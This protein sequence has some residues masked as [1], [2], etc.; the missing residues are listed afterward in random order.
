M[1]AKVIRIGAKYCTSRL[2]YEH[3]PERWEV[4]AEKYLREK[5]ADSLQYEMGEKLESDNIVEKRI[6]L[7]VASPEVFWKT[8]RQEA[9]KIAEVFMSK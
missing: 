5:I 9:E 8:V 2:E 3:D 4:F 6:D 1:E 7:Y